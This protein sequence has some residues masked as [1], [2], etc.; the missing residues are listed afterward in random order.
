MNRN[1]DILANPYIVLRRFLCICISNDNIQLYYYV[2][3]KAVV[4]YIRVMLNIMTY[5][6]INSRYYMYTIVLKSIYGTRGASKK[7]ANTEKKDPLH[8][9]KSSHVKKKP[10]I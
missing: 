7:V 4:F 8:G 6:I 2:S 5:Y 1:A 3:R 10:V 9:E